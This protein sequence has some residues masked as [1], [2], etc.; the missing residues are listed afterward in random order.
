MTAQKTP[1]NSSFHI[2]ELHDYIFNKLLFIAILNDFGN[3]IS[4]NKKGSSLQSIHQYYDFGTLKDKTPKVLISDQ[5]SWSGYLL[6]KSDHKKHSISLSKHQ[7]YYVWVG[8]ELDHKVD[9]DKA[10]EV[11]RLKEKVTQLL[12]KEKNLQALLQAK[13]LNEMLEGKIENSDDLT[14]LSDL[15]M[16]LEYT[17]NSAQA[18]FEN[19]ERQRL[20]FEA[21]KEGLWDWN[22]ITRKVY[23]SKSFYQ[24][25]GIDKQEN[26]EDISALLNLIHPEDRPNTIRM[27]QRDILIKNGFQ[28]IF[29][30]ITPAGKTLWVLLKVAVQKDV[31][32]KVIR[33]IGKHSD[34]TFFK[35]HT[36][37]I[38]K[39]V[40]QTEDKERERFAK[41][42]HDGL[43]QTLTASIY[44]LDEFLKNTQNLN[45]EERKIIQRIRE[46]VRD[47]TKEGRN[48]AHNIMPTCIE[49]LGLVGSIEK[50][51][52]TYR[53]I[54]N[55]EVNFF[56]KIEKNAMSFAQQH[57]LLRVTQEAIQNAFKHGKAKEVS[58]SLNQNLDLITLMIE[59][60]GCGF[61][62]KSTMKKEG[63]GLGLLSMKDRVRTIEGTIDIDSS[64]N[65]GT[66]IIIQLKTF[67]N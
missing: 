28:S 66:C 24:M 48:I 61:D 43:G 51:V 36:D 64:P 20:S 45:E 62:V 1:N 50:L 65:Y 25:M 7:N 19:E 10:K 44:Q 59:D 3:V 34:I 22:H 54:N 32:G 47:A 53:T 12:T 13:A 15:P 18:I 41:E 29:R 21:S 26:E 58:I 2:E 5:E 40:L 57:I 30:M 60:N 27:L 37:N 39:A 4:T 6:H 35:N 63:N 17:A 33:V 52:D 38:Q 16:E 31:D 9:Q 46:Q 23:Y 8:L 49:K 42:I 56:Y 55:K 67:T 14:L 11:I